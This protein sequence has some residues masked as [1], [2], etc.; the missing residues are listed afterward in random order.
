MGLGK[1]PMRKHIGLMLAAMTISFM[2]VASATSPIITHSAQSGRG[3]AGDGSETANGSPE[4]PQTT[5]PQKSLPDKANGKGAKDNACCAPKGGLGLS[6]LQGRVLDIKTG[7][8]VCCALVSLFLTDS[9]SVDKK[10]ITKDPDGTTQPCKEVEPAA[11]PMGSC[12]GC[13]DG[14]PEMTTAVPPPPGPDQVPPPEKAPP[15]P[16]LPAPPTGMPP[17]KEPQKP[18]VPAAPAPVLQAKTDLKGGYALK[19]K[20]GT[21]IMTVEAEGYLPFKGEIGV[22]PGS[23]F[24][25]DIALTPAPERPAPGCRL[26][27]DIIDAGTGKGIAGARV[28]I[29]YLPQGFPV[30]EEQLKEMVGNYIGWMPG[31]PGTENPD[32]AMTPEEKQM[33]ALQLKERLARMKE[34]A[35]G[36]L[37][38]DQA[39]ALKEKLAQ[40]NAGADQKLTDD[41]IA[42]LRQELARLQQG[43]GQQP[44]ADEIAA[45]KEKLNGQL[46]EEQR[47]QLLGELE[48]LKNRMAQAQE[49]G[50]S[51]GEEPPAREPAQ[52]GD[53]PPQPPPPPT[54]QPPA[55]IKDQVLMLLAVLCD[56]NGHFGAKVLSG[57]VL[58]IAF[59]RSY[60]PGWA[61][62][63]LP[64]DSVTSL[65]LK[66]EKMPC[67]GPGGE[68]PLPEPPVL[69]E[70]DTSGIPPDPR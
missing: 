40:I 65:D 5:G 70:K 59:A 6:V 43:M 7:K 18:P 24:T 12:G 45:L 50:E 66:L 60:M 41:Q 32:G 52:P 4:K 36:L 22:P 55:D 39:A 29:V 23:L 27:G 28:M 9:V 15:V 13:G 33:L 63:D 61:V 44:S 53:R 30:T 3:S 8:P 38:D 14:G 48:A 42:Q 64:A 46:T 69:P 35:G 62:V 67:S 37:T 68:P 31:A 16:G 2:F 34:G 57:K 19:V 11:K 56:D 20:A 25:H 26:Y 51:S 54:P 21:F 49:E 10:T 47:Q 1:M 58:V 17:A